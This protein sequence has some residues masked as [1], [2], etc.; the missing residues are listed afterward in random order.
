MKLL[1][2]ESSYQNTNWQCSNI[3]K[4]QKTKHT[5]RLVTLNNKNQIYCEHLYHSIV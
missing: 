4:S 2:K 1:Q 3:T 5:I